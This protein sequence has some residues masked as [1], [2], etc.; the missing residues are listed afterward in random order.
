MLR[1]LLKLNMTIGNISAIKFYST[2]PQYC[3]FK[4]TTQKFQACHILVNVSAFVLQ[5][6]S[7]TDD[8]FFQVDAI[9]PILYNF[10]K[11]EWLN[12]PKLPTYI[13]REDCEDVCTVL[14]SLCCVFS[15]YSFIFRKKEWQ[16]IERIGG[17][18]FVAFKPF[19]HSILCV[20]RS[21]GME[22]VYWYS[23]LTNSWHKK[24]EIVIDSNAIKIVAIHSSWNN[25]DTCKVYRITDITLHLMYQTNNILICYFY[26]YYL[27]IIYTH[28]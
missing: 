14:G 22:G 11:R 27:I 9:K 26:R 3:N 6:R 4:L 24:T 19:E 12:F 7:W 28:Y 8:P 20:N 2:F 25:I 17:K 16:K 10:E 1:K 18:Y 5:S 13:N 15:S 23:I 21:K